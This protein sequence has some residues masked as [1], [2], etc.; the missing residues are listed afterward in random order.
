MKKVKR[1]K[2]A[3]ALGDEIAEYLGTLSMPKRGLIK[4]WEK[5]AA[6]YLLEHTDSIFY[7]VKAKN[8]TVLVYID[9]AAYATELNMDKELY[10]IKM[11]QE[12]GK[13]ITE[14]KFLVSRK[15]AQ[16]KNTSE[17]SESAL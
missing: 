16:R 14:V 17:T 5:I 3:V 10:R 13:D 1:K 15:S 2:T 9:S 4:H 6:P 8:N 7:D 12:T 11:Q